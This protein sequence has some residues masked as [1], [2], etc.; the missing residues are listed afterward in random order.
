[1]RAIAGAAMNWRKYRDLSDEIEGHLAEKVDELIAQGMSPEQARHMAQRE[2]GNL[3]RI[4]ERSHDVW[5]WHWIE[6]ALADLQYA[7]RQL[8]RSP[9]F[10]AGAVITLALG[11]G[12]NSAIYSV[13][14]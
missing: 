9:A 12:A 10:T 7:L 13:M 14:N 2:F 1:M 5:R 4:K 6:D 11:I 8:L 3:L